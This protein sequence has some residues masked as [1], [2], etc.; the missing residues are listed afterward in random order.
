MIIN[1]GTAKLE[2]SEGK[3]SRKL[4]VFYNPVMK[5]NRDISILLLNSIE[6]TAMQIAD[7]LAGSGVRAIRFLNELDE[8]KIKNISLNDFKAEPII[9][10]LKL[11]KLGKDKRITLE[12]SD[13]NLF[14]LN[15]LGF[16]YIDID[17]FGSPNPFLQSAI[18]RLARKGILAVTATDTAALAG[19]SEKACVRKYWAKPLR[20]EMMHEIGIRILI[21]RVQLIGSDNEK[22]LIPI[23]SYFKDHYY[24]VFFRCE[25]GRQKADEIMKQHRFLQYDPKTLD[26][27]I[28]EKVNEKMQYAG[29]LWTGN[30]WDKELVEKMHNGCDKEN[31]K[32]HDLLSI[33]KEESKIDSVGFYDL[34]KL[35]NIRKESIKKVEKVL[36]PG[37]ISRTHFLGW[38]IKCLKQP[39]L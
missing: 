15:S 14:L 1:E 36:V 34:Q 9:K 5:L 39:P 33:L 24:R 21:R 22:A 8:N 29:P 16:D 38:G 4:P 12:S 7:P 32:M 6:N 31:K 20:N 26:V 35:A 11:N 28:V 23:F 37:K 27:K 30:L 18:I 19:S 10:N 17:P 25:K 13:A 2:V 3:I